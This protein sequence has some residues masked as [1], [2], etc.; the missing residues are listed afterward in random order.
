MATT[1]KPGGMA[2]ILSPWLIH[3]GSRVADAAQALE[4]RAIRVDA[5][6]G[7]AELARVAALD[8]PAQLGAMVISP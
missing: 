1:S 8:R 3:T 2:V 6:L 4:Q 5:D 7:A